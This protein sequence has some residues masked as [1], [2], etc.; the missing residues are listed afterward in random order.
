[1][2][3]TGI[4]GGT[5]DPVHY[6]H[7]RLAETAYNELSLDKVIFMPAYIPPHKADNIVSDWEHRVNML[8]LAISD[9][10]YFNIS[11]LEKELQGR[12]YTARTLSRKLC[13]ERCK[14]KI[15]SFDEAWGV[16]Q[17]AMADYGWYHPQE[18]FN[19]AEIACACRDKED[20]AALLAKADEYSSRY[21]GV[22]HILDMVKFDASSTCIRENIRN[23]KRCDGIIPEKVLEYIKEN[24]LYY[25]T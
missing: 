7:I 19:N 8:K 15:L 6:G 3:R 10:P 18:I 20:R 1:M 21:G 9:I 12:S 11:F 14:P 25:G 17:K 24:G 16:V 5:F 23:R 13:M 22:S 4:F 2:I